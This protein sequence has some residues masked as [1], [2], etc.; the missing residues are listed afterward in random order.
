MSVL[1]GWKSVFEI[2]ASWDTQG[3]DFK[4]EVVW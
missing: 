1:R 4:E 2:G 3:E